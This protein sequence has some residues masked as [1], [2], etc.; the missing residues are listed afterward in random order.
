MTRVITPGT[1]IETNILEEKK[2][3]YLLA[4][5]LDADG[6]KAGL[7]Y[8]DVSTGEMFVLELPVPQLGEELT[9]IAPTEVLVR[10][11]DRASLESASAR[12]ARR[13]ARQRTSTR[14]APPRCSGSTCTRAWRS[15]A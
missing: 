15:W 1:V 11:Q 12:S 4:L 3:N 9:R 7:A 2:N 10:A 6:K 8:A 5:S 14:R 13:S